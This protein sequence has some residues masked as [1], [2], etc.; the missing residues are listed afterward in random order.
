[1]ENF[2]AYIIS[3][4]ILLSFV[5]F[6]KWYQY[7]KDKKIRDL[8][9]YSAI[10]G[11]CP[12]IGRYSYINDLISHVKNALFDDDIDKQYRLSE[13]NEEKYLR[14]IVEAYYKKK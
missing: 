9:S 6:Y 4:Y 13:G 14:E 12:A 10:G 1:M 5:A 7:S 8:V 2:H 3:I 11:Y